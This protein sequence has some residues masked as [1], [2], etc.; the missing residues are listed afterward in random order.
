MIHTHPFAELGGSMYQHILVAVDD[1]DTSNR[2]LDEA[3]RLAKDQRAVLR[4]VFVVD[5]TTIYSD[6]QI[7]DPGEIER[8]WIRIGNEILHKAENT[9]RKEGV[10]AEIKLL[11]TKN[12]GDRIANAIVAEAEAWP[13]DLMVAGTHGRS[14]LTHLLM[15]SVAEG[16]LR[17]TSVPI[18]LIRGK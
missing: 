14:G 17:T 15:G 5:E 18:L 13:A 8:E 9:A 10:T 7:S 11:Q 6:A 1:S 12:V 3:I 16:L 4:L 2:A